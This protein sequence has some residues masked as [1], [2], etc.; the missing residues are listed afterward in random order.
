MEQEGKY[1]WMTYQEVYNVVLKIGS[2]IRSCGL[3]PV[4]EGCSA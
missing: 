3:G 1:T 4:S 2:A